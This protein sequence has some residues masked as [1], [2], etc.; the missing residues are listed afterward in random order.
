[1]KF[2]LILIAAR[3]RWPALWRRRLIR[4]TG[5]YQAPVK[6]ILESGLLPYSSDNLLYFTV[7]AAREFGFARRRPKRV[8]RSRTYAPAVSH[9]SEFIVFL[10]VARAEAKGWV[11]SAEFTGERVGRRYRIFFRAQLT[12]AGLDHVV[13]VN[14]TMAQAL[15]DVQRNGPSPVRAVAELFHPLRHHMP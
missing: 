7:R 2:R 3:S 4:R 14:S 8:S 9:T 13:E 10:T 6:Q 11:R 12:R 5:G 15:R 1:M